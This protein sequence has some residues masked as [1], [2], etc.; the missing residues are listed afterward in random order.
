[1]PTRKFEEIVVDLEGRP[2]VRF[3][4]CP[5]ALDKIKGHVNGAAAKNTIQG[6]RERDIAG[7]ALKAAAIEKA[8]EDGMRRVNVGHVKRGWRENLV[9]SMGPPSPF[10]DPPEDCFQRSVIMRVDE[11]RE[12]SKVFRELMSRIE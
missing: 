7:L 9:I 8:F 6:D 10:C 3:Y 11:L 2:S 1:M 4:I 12:R 5:S